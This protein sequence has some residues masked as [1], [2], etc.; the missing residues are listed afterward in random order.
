[1]KLL[2]HEDRSLK[3]ARNRQRVGAGQS[4]TISYQAGRL[5]VFLRDYIGQQIEA[6][7]PKRAAVLYERALVVPTKKTGCPLAA[8]SHHL[9]LRL[10]KSFFA[11]ALDRGHVG[12][13]PFAKVVPVGKEDIGKSAS[14]QRGEKVPG[15]CLQLL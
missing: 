9:Y 4:G 7:T 1:M 11:W 5:R 15:C 6:L 10:A 2:Y 12:V 13:N 14:S 8:A 3:K